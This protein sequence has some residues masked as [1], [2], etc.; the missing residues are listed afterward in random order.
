M[1]TIFPFLL[2]LSILGCTIQKPVSS[3]K[4]NN[5]GDYTVKYLFEYGGC[6]VYRFLD[7]GRTVYFTNCN[8]EAISKTDSTEVKN[9]IK[10]NKN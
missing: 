2:M 5:N 7:G 3:E 6:K 1:K 8:G 10:L 9:T 4:S